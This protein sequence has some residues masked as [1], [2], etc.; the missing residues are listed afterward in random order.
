MNKKL[1]KQIFGAITVTLFFPP[2]NFWSV[3]MFLDFSFGK[4]W[5]DYICRIHIQ[6]HSG[7]EKHLVEFRCTGRGNRSKL[8]SNINATCLLLYSI[9]IWIGSVTACRWSSGMR[10]FFF[11]FLLFRSASVAYGG[12][13]TKDQIG[14]AAAGLHHSHSN[15]RS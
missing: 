13:H 10:P 12:S 2:L 11:F 15:A 4:V 3:C 1:N 5:R 8:V 7:K 9:G 6:I 14:A